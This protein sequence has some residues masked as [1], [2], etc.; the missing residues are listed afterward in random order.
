MLGW[1]V[2][3]VILSILDPFLLMVEFGLFSEL[4]YSAGLVADFN[5][6]LLMSFF[7]ILYCY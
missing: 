3:Q 5:K 6:T 1:I 4:S 7:R 2:F